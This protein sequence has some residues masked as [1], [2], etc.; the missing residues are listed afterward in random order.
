MQSR[1]RNTDRAQ[2][3]KNALN[4][5]DEPYK[6]VG[7]NDPCPCGN[8]KKCKK[9]CLKIIEKSRIGEIESPQE[10]LKKTKYYPKLSFDPVSEL[11][12]GR[13][14]KLPGRLYLEN[15]YDR[16]AILIDY[17]AYLGYQTLKHTQFDGFP[18]PGNTS[19]ETQA[20]CRCVLS[21]SK[22][23]ARGENVPGGHK[24]SG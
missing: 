14:D 13:F 12:A 17:Y 10:R 16:D 1:F 24:G 18:E 5:H 15:K 11:V 19:V 4:L 20:D 3:L 7:R 2:L 21:E 23:I 9:C 22:S 6:N 8:G